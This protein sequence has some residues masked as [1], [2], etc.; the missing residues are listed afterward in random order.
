MTN[1]KPLFVFLLL[2][3]PIASGWPQSEPLGRL[4]FTPQQRAMLDRQ[5]QLSLLPNRASQEDNGSFTI[6]GLVQRSSGR[7]TT[8]VNGIPNS[9]AEA[10]AGVIAR[11]MEGGR[12]TVRIDGE[13]KD[14][15]LKV[16]E[17]YRRNSGERQDLL[18]G[19][20]IVI[21]RPGAA[22]R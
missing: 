20:E 21:R 13:A 6:N 18:N 7:H 17:T 5:R 8:W 4:F 19:G 1:R 14:P 2:Q 3:L 10:A 16:G 9:D 11:P 15:A 22:S 12:G